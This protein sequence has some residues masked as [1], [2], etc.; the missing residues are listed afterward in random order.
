MLFLPEALNFIGRSPAESVAAAELLD[1]PSMSYYRSLAR[2]TG[3]WLSLGG[4]QEVGPDSQ[5][6]FNTHAIISSDGDLVAA[7][8]RGGCCVW[9]GSQLLPSCSCI[10]ELLPPQTARYICL[11]SKCRTD[12]C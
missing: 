12:Q 5:H 9:T 7:C 1:G 3:L 10:A 6:V 8:E 2:R 11:M 4:L